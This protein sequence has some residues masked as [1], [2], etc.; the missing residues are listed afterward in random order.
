MSAFSSLNKKSASV[1]A[2]SVF[3][4][5]V[6]PINKKL[7]KGL[8]GSLKP[9]RLRLIASETTCTASFCPMTR[10]C[11]TFSSSRYF[12]F[13]LE[14]IL[15]TGIPVHELTTRA[16]SSSVTSCRK[17][18]LR[19][20]SESRFFC[21]ASAAVSSFS[22]A[23]ILLYFN[24]AAFSRLPSR[25]NFST[26]K[27]HCSSSALM[28]RLLSMSDFSF[29]HWSFIASRSEEM[30]ASSFSSFLSR[31]TEA[32]SVSFASDCFSIDN[33]KIFRSSWSSSVG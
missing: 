28:L 16:T 8:L 2:S 27:R 29:C 23:G 5:P 15:A 14:S 24:S 21:R 26:S 6:G 3:P 10:L 4:T 1:F 9:E 12:C 11:S 22:R 19:S 7:P 33:C 17:S 18:E 25:V 32:A 30:S 20:L 13:S 31:S